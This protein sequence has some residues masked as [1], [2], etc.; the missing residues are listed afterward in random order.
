MSV[1]KKVYKPLSLALSIAGGMLAGKAFNQVWKRIGDDEPE[2]PDP[3]DLQRS[4]QEVLIAAAIHGTVY[5]LVKAL[6]DR[7][8]A[9]GYNALTHEDPS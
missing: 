5:G 6:V 1:S 7:A 8:G 3:K 2:A 4:L 9:K